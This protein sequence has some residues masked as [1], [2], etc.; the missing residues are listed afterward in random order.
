M[1]TLQG[2]G[3]RSALNILHELAES[4]QPPR[5]G[6]LWLNVGT[7]PILDRLRADYLESLLS[8]YEGRD[9]AGV[10]KW[11]EATYGNGKTQ[12]LRCMQEHAWTSGY[13]TAFVELSQDECP[14]DR[15]DRIYGVVARS[16]QTDDSPV[17]GLDMALRA[18]LDRMFPGVLSGLPD[19]E[20]I[21]RAEHWVETALRATPVES[22]A[23]R[24]AAAAFLGSSLRGDE[25]G[26]RIAGGYLR[27]EPLPM[28]ELKAVGVFEKLDK[29]SGFRLLRSLCQLL[30]RSG[31]ARGTV[32]LF[33]E[34][35]RSLSLMSSRAQKVA[36]E[37][38]LNI[39]NKCNCGDLPGTMF[40]YAV[41]PTFFTD[42]VTRYPALQQRCAASSRVR[43]DTVNGLREHDLLTAIGG[44]IVRIAETAYG[45]DLAGDDSLAASLRVIT[46]SVL[47]RSMGD[48]SRRMLVKVWTQYLREGRGR[49][50]RPLSADEAD[51]LLDGVIDDRDERALDEEGE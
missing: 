44:Q 38:L 15:P 33:D 49:E 28:S 14:L 5:Q 7:G 2:L 40:L 4:G 30:Q 42:F 19:D 46:D 26:A 45:E 3:P 34:A 12:F 24:E 29:S 8:P 13:V 10:C 35:R 47:T 50:G 20:L 23:L 41:M 25:A 32:I 21:A 48:G 6:A 27:G 43:L 36:C 1:S 17:S 22:T 51:R 16:I 18:L 9:G 11:V 39:I 37:N 31:L